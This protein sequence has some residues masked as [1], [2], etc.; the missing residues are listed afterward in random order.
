[1]A[2]LEQAEGHGAPATAQCQWILERWRRT[3]DHHYAVAPLRWA[4]TFFAETGEVAGARTCAA[5][6]AQIA[7]DAGQAETMAALSHALGE[8]ALLDGN[9]RQAAGQF[10]QALA[11]LRGIDAPF[12]RAETAAARRRGAGARRPA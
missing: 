1:M 2:I 3:E 4:A 11:L 12:D 6:L 7:A 8:T 9:P 5:S 10:A